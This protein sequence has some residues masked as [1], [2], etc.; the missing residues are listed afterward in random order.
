[1]ERFVYLRLKRRQ[2]SQTER[3]SNVDVA[4]S[5]DEVAV[6]ASLSSAQPVNEANENSSKVHSHNLPFTTKGKGTSILTWS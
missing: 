4:N 6:S 2:T 3:P 1:M 5:H